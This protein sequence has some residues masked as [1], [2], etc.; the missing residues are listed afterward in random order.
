MNHKSDEPLVCCLCGAVIETEFGGWK[1][2]HNPA[3]LGRESRDRCCS[4]CNDTR[5]I[6]VRLFQATTRGT[7]FHIPMDELKKRLKDNES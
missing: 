1:W 7:A 5:V 6:P 4:I 2:G 3:P